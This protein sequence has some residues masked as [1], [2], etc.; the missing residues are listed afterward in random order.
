MELLSFNNFV[1]FV[2]LNIRFSR[3][4]LGPFAQVLH[5]FFSEWR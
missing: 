3:L 2:Q 4:K 1:G 5:F